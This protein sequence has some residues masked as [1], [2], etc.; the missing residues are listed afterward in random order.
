MQKPV[1][2]GGLAAAITLVAS[3]ACAEAPAVYA[4]IKLAS[5]AAA[6]ARPVNVGGLDWTCTGDACAGATKTDPAGWSPMYFCKKV[7]AKLG[8]L[9]S[10]S[11]RQREMSAADLATCNSAAPK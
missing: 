1:Q 11:L 2:L 8:P 6:P 10:W 5:A 4:H 9:A 3:A 7:A